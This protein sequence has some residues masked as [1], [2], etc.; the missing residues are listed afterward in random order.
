VFLDKLGEL[1]GGDSNRRPRDETFLIGF[2]VYH[3]SELPAIFCQAVWSLFLQAKRGDH[4]AKLRA[5]MFE[6]RIGGA[7]RNKV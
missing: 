7:K 6:E 3:C 1:L 4:T 5:L 2:W